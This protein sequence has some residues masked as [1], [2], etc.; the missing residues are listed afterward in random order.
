MQLLEESE[1]D[2]ALWDS[3]KAFSVF[4]QN[5]GRW[6]R[7]MSVTFALSPDKSV[8]RK[9]KLYEQM[10]PHAW[11]VDERYATSHQELIE[12]HQQRLL[13]EHERFQR[14]VPHGFER[15][16][17]FCLHVTK[18]SDIAP[19]VH[20]LVEMY[21]LIRGDVAFR[22]PFS[23]RR[24]VVARTVHEKQSSFWSDRSHSRQSIRTGQI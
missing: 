18:E 19:K 21:R 15:D 6:A 24:K 17:H 1:L 11:L 9:V 5:E 3:R 22:A 12:A 23:S 7:T 10:L 13:A 2:F 14:L 4:R 20:R 16:G 8:S